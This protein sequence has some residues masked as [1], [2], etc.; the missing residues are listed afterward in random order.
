MAEGCLAGSLVFGSGWLAHAEPQP[1]F[2][3]AD[4]NPGSERAGEVISP[5]NYTQ[6]ITAWYFGREW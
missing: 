5:R 6:Q 3:L 2:A 1:A 4:V